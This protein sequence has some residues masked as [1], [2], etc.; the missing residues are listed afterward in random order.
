M[1]TGRRL[2]L[3]PV[4]LN[5]QYQPHRTMVR[6]QN[7]VMDRC[8]GDP[9]CDSV[10]YDKIVNAPAGIVFPGIEAVAPPAVHTSGIGVQVAE[11][12]RKTTG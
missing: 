1:K 5:I 9:V 3:R 2:I 8:G 11:G 10:G 6:T 12:I 7:L 4:R